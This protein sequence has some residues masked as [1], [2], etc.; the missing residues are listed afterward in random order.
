MGY[1]N[2]LS[3]LTFLLGSV[4]AY[5]LSGQVDV[6]WLVPFAA[7]NFLYI[8]AADLIPQFTGQESVRDKLVHTASFVAGFAALYLVALAAR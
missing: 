6:I 1:L 8:A 5:L 4:L 7:G 2:V 3:A